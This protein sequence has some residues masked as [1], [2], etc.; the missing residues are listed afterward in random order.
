MAS[1]DDKA[2]ISMRLALVLGIFSNGEQ[3]PL[4]KS[5][6]MNLDAEEDPSGEIMENQRGDDEDSEDNTSS[7]LESPDCPS[8]QDMSNQ[9]ESKTTADAERFQSYIG[10]TSLSS[11]QQVVSLQQR[12]LST[13]NV[14]DLCWTSEKQPDNYHES[15]NVISSNFEMHPST[16]KI[17]NG[18]EPKNTLG[19]REVERMH[20]DSSITVNAASSGVESEIPDENIGESAQGIEM[21]E[22]MVIPLQVPVDKP[23]MV[24]SGTGAKCPATRCRRTF[25]TRGGLNLHWSKIHEEKEEKTLS[26]AEGKVEYVNDSRIRGAFKGSGSSNVRPQRSRKERT[27]QSD[28]GS[29]FLSS[30]LK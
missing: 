21:V 22:P 19:T 4:V 25:Q 1:P 16:V 29:L 23:S 17:T 2:G 26:Q 3:V 18:K 30:F 7:R 15:S 12:S 28:N 8:S 9:N 11:N 20:E 13:Q 10:K 6:L 24:G 5:I 27:K 14:E